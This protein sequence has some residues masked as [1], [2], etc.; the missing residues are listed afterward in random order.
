MRAA[1]ELA[2]ERDTGARGL[3]S[4]I[5]SCLLNVM[6]EAPSHDEINKVVISE[7]VI[8]GDVPPQ[9]YSRDG[10]VMDLSGKIDSAA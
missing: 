7:S 6:F 3:R 8:R 4:I 5:E 9:V 2:I 10:G 1:A